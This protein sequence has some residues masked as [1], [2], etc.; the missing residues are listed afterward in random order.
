MQYVQYVQYMQSDGFGLS[1]CCIIE[2]FGRRKGRRKGGE[3]WRLNEK[4]SSIVSKKVFT[5]ERNSSI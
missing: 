2:F 1:R 4:C 5:V 3:A